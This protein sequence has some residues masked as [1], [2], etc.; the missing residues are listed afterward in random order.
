MSDEVAIA[1]LEELYATLPTIECQGLCWNACGPIK[2]SGVERRRIEA[3]GV[4]IPP[5]SHERA[6]QWAAGARIPCPALDEDNRCTVYDVRPLIC[7]A[8][9]VGRADLACIHGCT[10]TGRRLK[11]MEILHLLRQAELLGGSEF[12]QDAD[13]DIAVYSDP[14]VARLLTRYAYGDRSVAGDLANAVRRAAQ[15]IEEGES[16]HHL[17]RRLAPDLRRP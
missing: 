12:G 1:A 5:F 6:L 2:M 4:D 9:G 8:W 3:R 13:V 15:R 17:N 10:R 16:T 11:F 14:E 7:R